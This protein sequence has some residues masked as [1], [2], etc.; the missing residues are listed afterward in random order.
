MLARPTAQCKGKLVSPA[1][2]WPGASS[3]EIGAP[4][5]FE[6]TA[7]MKTD[8]STLRRAMIAQCR[9]MNAIGLNQGTS[10]NISARCGGRMLITPSAVPYDEMEP[11]MIAAMPIEGEGAWEGSVAP[12]SEWRFH[13]DLTRSRPD[14][15]AIVHSHAIHCTTLAI[16]RRPIPA[17]HYMIAAFGGTD[18][19]CADYAT[20]GT[21]ALSRAV[22]AAMQGRNA[23][24]MA[25]HGMIAAGPDLDQAMWLAVELETLARQYFNTL[26]IG[27]PVL[28]GEA[29]IAD[30]AKSFANYGLQDAHDRLGA[31]NPA[32][33]TPDPGD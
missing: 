14:I 3:G 32:L 16:A 19:R 27:G 20:F 21:E 31:R 24:L 26:L 13:L 5:T 7:P 30:A 10:G 25:N 28:L 18:I 8:E 4:P 17:L 6:G 33:G 22:L 23:C 29:E 12:S 11:E 15:G 9:R 2:L 1:L